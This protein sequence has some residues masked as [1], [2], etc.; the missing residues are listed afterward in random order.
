MSK[1]QRLHWANSLKEE[2]KEEEGKAERE[3]KAV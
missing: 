3:E 2:R 1:E